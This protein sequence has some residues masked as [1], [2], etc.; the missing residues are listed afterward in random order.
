MY[1]PF[2]LWCIYAC[3]E[4]YREGD[5]WY[6]RNLIP[7]YNKSKLI[8]DPHTLWFIQRFVIGLAL[9][10]LV[11]CGKYYIYS[12]LYLF[13]LGCSFP[14]LHDGF[15][16]I[17]RNNIDKTVYKERFFDYSITS[18]ARMTFNFEV[19]LFLFV[20]GFICCTLTI[21]RL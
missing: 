10:I 12:P 17:R 8:H 1:I 21:Y 13:G 3:I 7:I 20:V 2:I 18:T 15:Y 5:Y 9:T 4:G 14:L 6:S 16:Y 11:F 19:R